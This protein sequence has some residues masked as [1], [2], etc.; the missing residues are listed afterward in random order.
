VLKAIGLK[1][2]ILG[3]AMVLLT[4]AASPAL[5]A[6]AGAT[7]PVELPTLIIEAPASYAAWSEQLRSFDRA[8]LAPAMQLTGL[9]QPGA[10]VRLVLAERGSQLEAQAPGWAAGYAQGA[11]GVVV[12][13]PWRVASYPD[14]TLESLVQHEVT[15]VL[16]ARAAGGAPVPRWFNEGLAMAAGHA[17]SLEDRARTTLDMVSGGGGSLAEL[18][19]GFTRGASQARGAYALSYAFVRDLLSDHG[20]DA[21][22]RILAGVRAGQSFEEAYRQATGESLAAAEEQFW[23]YWRLW[24]RWVPL[25]AGSGVLWVPITLLALLAFRRRRTRNAEVMRRFEAEER[26]AASAQSWR[27]P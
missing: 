24:G 11:S 16:V 17:W 15:H 27:D 23:S 4:A 6:A 18:D 2:T 14:D 12:L 10:P 9:R 20:A 3:A 1:A 25:L 19:R 13:M 21:P 26:A 8:R 22:A 7:A 5:D